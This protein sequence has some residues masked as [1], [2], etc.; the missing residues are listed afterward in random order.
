MIEDDKLEAACDWSD[1]RGEYG[2]S[3]EHLSVAHR[4]FLAG[5]KAGRYGEQAGVLK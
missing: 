3:E 5:W 2:V 1:Y 4:A